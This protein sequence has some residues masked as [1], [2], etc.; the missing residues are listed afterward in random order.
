MLF[1]LCT[2]LPSTSQ[3]T[4][5]KKPTNTRREGVGERERERRER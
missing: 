1:I 4:P 2:L 3:F 5:P